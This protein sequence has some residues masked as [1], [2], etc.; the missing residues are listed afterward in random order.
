MMRPLLMPLAL[1]AALALAG[2]KSASEK[3]EDYYRS[4]M[5]YL[6][7]G[8]EERGLLELRNVFRYD[9]FHKEARRAYAEVLIKR[10][11]LSEA[12]GQYLRLIEQYPD[13]VD[14]RRILAEMALQQ[15]NWDEARRHGE[16][17]LQLTPGAPELEPIRISLAY[18]AAALL[19]DAPGLAALSKEAETLLAGPLAGNLLLTRVL[20]DSRLASEDPSQALPLVT[21]V[22]EG[23]PEM[24]DM[25]MLRYRLLVNGGDSAAI[26]AQLKRMA[27]L[28]PD[29]LQV[30]ATLVNWYV[31]N[32]E[33]DAAEA[34]LRGLAGDPK[35]ETGPHMSLVGMLE[36]LRGRE[37][38]LAELQ[39]LREANAGT[40][41]ADFY[42]AEL[43]RIDFAQGRQTEA[44]AA[45]RA[46]LASATASD[47]TRAIQVDLAR[48]L[49]A[50]GAREEATRLVAE[51]LEADRSNV[52][53]LKQ[54]A[55]WA[56][57]ADRPGD[58]IVDLRAALDQA[59]R[60]SEVLSLMAV[61]HERDGSMDLAGE[62]L[63]LALEASEGAVPETLRYADFLL[64]QNRLQIASRVLSDARN[65]HPR[66]LEILGVLS[67]VYIREKLWDRALEV[68]SAM[69][70]LPLNEAGVARV[71]AQRAA[72]LA[73][74]NRVDEGL[75]LLA[76][77]AQGSEA[78][79]GS[80]R[81]LQAQIESGRLEE[82]R[83]LLEELRRAH[84]EEAGLT[85]FDASLSGI[86]GK[87]ERAEAIWREMLAK[88]PGAE[89]PAQMLYGYLV[90]SGRR[91]EAGAVLDQA[92]AASETPSMVLRWLKAGDLEAQGRIEESIA[93]YEAM[94]AEDG[95]NLVVAN[96]LASLIASH[97]TDA[98]G[99]ERAERIARR[100]RGQS[101]PA[102]Q[103]TYG[104]IAFRRGNLE[105]ARS[106]LEPAA[107]GLPEDAVVQMHLGLLYEKLDR[108][109]EAVTQLERAAALGA[110]AQTRAEA[111]SD[112]SVKATARTLSRNLA[113]VG[114]ALERLNAAPAAA[115]P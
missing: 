100:L 53:A 110:A 6:A 109:A 113:E 112:E 8:D 102:F 76:Q 19:R 21:A 87:P 12:Y 26:G 65:R 57:G 84:P 85:L 63:A 92:L 103:D 61:A 54:R 16:A 78:L 23:N 27:E 105:E 3:A 114:P 15:G 14:V 59:P 91:D 72:I 64:K 104:W 33:I 97:S 108:K 30:R 94:Y 36:R 93:V 45:L 17:A 106:H 89:M 51:V 95:A 43:A 18:Q 1:A 25:Q 49:D 32:G 11:D 48:M 67:E 101:M 44:I 99:L 50:T 10:G 69:E 13:T 60:D 52:A 96:N 7:K 90:S 73:G 4:G 37:T 34:Y 74:Q 28:F 115:K 111:Q 29:N 80:V 31:E 42:G 41:N 88:T 62:R 75:A 5:E 35:G 82:A 66:S 47:Q 70:A 39:A 77:G 107:A 81:L 58:A 40:P 20:I 22:L 79:G 98:A 86:E 38:A 9:G 83:K 68:V 2:C 24:Y 46:I 55:I 56:I 71:R